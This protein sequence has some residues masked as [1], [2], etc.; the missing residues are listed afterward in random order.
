MYFLFAGL[1]IDYISHSGHAYLW[2]SR[3]LAA[4]EEKDHKENKTPIPSEEEEGPF[5]AQ[6][7]ASANATIVVT[8]RGVPREKIVETAMRNIG[9]PLSNAALSSILSVSMLGF[10]RYNFTHI[11]ILFPCFSLFVSSF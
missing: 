8:P 6:K 4:I 5:H 3:Q 11:H 7:D 1:C 10:S 9:V 2:A